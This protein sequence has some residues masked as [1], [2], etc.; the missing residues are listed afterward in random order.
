LTFIR[1][2]EETQVTSLQQEHNIQICKR[3][4]YVGSKFEED[5]R[6]SVIDAPAIPEYGM[7]LVET[8]DLMDLTAGLATKHDLCLIAFDIIPE[9]TD[10]SDLAA[11]VDDLLQG[12]N[13]F[14][15]IRHPLPLR[16]ANEYINDTIWNLPLPY[17]PVTKNQRLHIQNWS[18]E[19]QGLQ[20]PISNSAERKMNY[21]DNLQL[22]LYFLSHG[23]T[24]KD[25]CVQVEALVKKSYSRSS[26]YGSSDYIDPTKT[27]VERDNVGY[28]RRRTWISL[29]TSLQPWL[30]KEPLIS[31]KS[32]FIVL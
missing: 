32:S 7:V 31:V 20:I 23:L 13:I 6:F 10:S 24:W 22:S 9:I 14:H 25:S 30:N 17:R 21:W 11:V 5:H 1:D 3:C 16:F 26:F 15:T 4:H 8:L 29:T 12:R 19:L 2:L 28:G 18:L 27:R